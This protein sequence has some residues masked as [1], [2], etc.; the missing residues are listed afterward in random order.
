MSVHRAPLMYPARPRLRAVAIGGFLVAA[1]LAACA[2]GDEVTPEAELS[3][4]L[5]PGAT[6]T[7]SPALPGVRDVQVAATGR[8]W[9]ELTWTSTPG[10]DGFAVW[11]AYSEPAALLA[12]SGLPGVEHWPDPSAEAIEWAVL[13]EGT[14]SV[15]SIFVQAV[16][17]GTCNFPVAARAPGEVV[18]CRAENLPPD[19]PVVFLVRPFSLPDL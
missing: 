9:A 3:G 12:R 13:G 17:D 8:T 14:Q 16:S 2:P 18:S 5:S 15:G 7:H 4:A 11:V 10:P 1:G 6:A 19:V